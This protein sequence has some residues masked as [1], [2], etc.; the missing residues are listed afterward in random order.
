MK[1]IVF[2]AILAMFACCRKKPVE[3]PEPAKDNVRLEFSLADGTEFVGSVR[4]VDVGVFDTSGELL[5]TERLTD[6]AD[7]LTMEPGN[8]RLVAWANVDGRVRFDM[9]GAPARVTYSDL[10]DFQTSG[11]GETVFY[12]PWDMER[13]AVDYYRL[14][15][16]D[17]GEVSGR[18]VLTPA[19]CSIEIYIEGLAEDAAPTV[20]MSG[21]AAALTYF[22]MRPVGEQVTATRP[23]RLVEH[24]GKRYHAAA[25]ASPLFNGDA[26]SDIRLS[27]DH[28]NGTYT[29]A[30]EDALESSGSDDYDP[31]DLKVGLLL[32]FIG[33][34]VEVSIPEWSS[35]EIG[36]RL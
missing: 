25:F 21:F 8:Y 17:E 6:A 34:R 7:V 28:P 33:A 5:R 23:T 20:D 16:P 31:S 12:G 36:V 18:I 10:A 32:N 11:A 1:R 29:T 30:L 2:F 13:Q 27:V 26:L 24:E 3:Q 9:E 22:G 35:S 4:W 15:V 14:E 19:Y